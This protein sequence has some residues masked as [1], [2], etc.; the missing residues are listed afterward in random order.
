MNDESSPLM[1]ADE[2]A[3]YLNIS[4]RTIKRMRNDGEFVA[5][6]MFGASARWRRSELISWLNS[7]QAPQ[8]DK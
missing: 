5:P 7:R 3:A 6:M 1:T 8:K 4:K 2:V